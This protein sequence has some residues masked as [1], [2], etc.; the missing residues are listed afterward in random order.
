MNT[1]ND[2]VTDMLGERYRNVVGNDSVEISGGG[3]FATCFK[4]FVIISHTMRRKGRF[5]EFLLNKARGGA[6]I[7]ITAPLVT[8]GDFE[9]GG[10][11]Y[12]NLNGRT[13]DGNLVMTVGKCPW[14]VRELYRFSAPLTQGRLMRRVLCDTPEGGTA[15]ISEACGIPFVDGSGVVSVDRLPDIMRLFLGVVGDFPEQTYRDGPN[16]LNGMRVTCETPISECRFDL[17]DFYHNGK[18]QS[19]ISLIAKAPYQIADYLNAMSHFIIPG[20]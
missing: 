18:Y 16:G 6:K 8:S 9:E 13:T 3:F 19:T 4:D 10:R 11:S 14:Y 12:Y 2:Y 5:G 1:A 17:E 20:V 15:W 7:S